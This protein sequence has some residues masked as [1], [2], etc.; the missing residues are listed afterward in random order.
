MERIKHLRIPSG[1][2]SDSGIDG[3]CSS[4]LDSATS[5]TTTASDTHSNKTISASSEKDGNDS[6][7]TI[8]NIK[9]EEFKTN[10]SSSKNNSES[11]FDCQSPESLEDDW[12][13]IESNPTVNKPFNSQIKVRNESNVADERDRFSP[14]EFPAEFQTDEGYDNTEDNNKSFRRPVENTDRS[15]L[16]SKE[17]KQRQNEEIVIMES[18]S[19]SSETG[20]WE[21]VFPQRANTELKESCKSFINNERTAC[22]SNS[23]RN[24]FDEDIINPQTVSSDQ[25]ISDKQ[26]N[27]AEKNLE[28]DFVP[29]AT[30]SLGACFIDAST[31]LDESEIAYSSFP[32]A[33]LTSDRNT[34]DPT[35]IK[36][37]DSHHQAANATNK[38]VTDVWAKDEPIQRLESFHKDFQLCKVNKA[39]A[40][41]INAGKYSGQV[42]QQSATTR[43][44]NLSDEQKLNKRDA[45]HSIEHDIKDQFCNNSGRPVALS[46]LNDL[47]HDTIRSDE[48]GPHFNERQEQERKQG[49]FL[50]QNSIQQFSGH[51]MSP[52]IPYYE[53]NHSDFSLPSAY[54][55]SSDPYNDCASTF[56]TS[57]QYS[58]NYGDAH[59]YTESN[60][61]SRGILSEAETV[62]FPDTPHNSIIHVNLSRNSIAPS[63]SAIASLS[64][65]EGYG[66]PSSRR[67]SHRDDDAMPIVSGGASVKDF[68][69][70]QC[71]S[72]TARRKDDICPIISQ[73]MSAA[74]FVQPKCESPAVRRRS[75]ACPIISLGM[76]PEDFGP[77]KPKCDSPSVR[78]RSDDCPIISLN[79]STADF[80]GN[81][82]KCDSPS[83]R[84]KTEACPIIS[85]GMSPKDFEETKVKPIERP[86]TSIVSSWVVDMSDCNGK[87]KRRC[88]ESS[89]SSIDNMA[90]SAADISLDR[91]SS[92][93][94]HK[95]LG[96]YVSLNDMKP[97]KLGE[98]YLSKS[99]NYKPTV[100]TVREQ[101]KKGTGFFVDFSESEH[102]LT[103]TPPPTK[104]TET[105]PVNNDKKNIFSMFIDFGDDKKS[106]SKKDSSPKLSS[107]LPN[108][109]DI[110]E[111]RSLENGM[112]SGNSDRAKNNVVFNESDSPVLARRTHSPAIATGDIKRHSW[113]TSKD[114]NQKSSFH[115]HK[116]SVSVSAPTTEKGIM[117]I[118]DKIPFISKT[119]S[120]SIDTPNSPYDDITC[121]KSLSS[122]SNNSLTSQSSVG[123]DAPDVMTKSAKRRQKDAKINETFDKSSQG[124]LTDGI[125]SKNSSP[126]YTT[127]TEDVTFQN[128]NDDYTRATFMETIPEAR[129]AGSPKKTVASLPSINGKTH[130]METLQ[131]T[132][133]K[134]KQLL[135]TVTEE[136]Q[137]SSYVK[138]S[139]MDKP[140]QRFELHQSEPMS[141]SAGSKIGKLFD[142]NKVGNRNSWHSMSRSVGNVVQISFINFFFNLL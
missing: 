109:S 11:T 22:V 87:G 91:N 14:V 60:R 105:P 72:P 131:A 121:S 130:T 33:N 90:R 89:T 54:S 93:G 49:N 30:T 12:S 117:N 20:S 58:S 103:A 1:S 80:D 45:D 78:R 137:I 26:T 71:D 17:E 138:L 84:R 3:G 74:D 39:E 129:E 101:K 85:L 122:Y 102:S 95:G 24:A 47:P 108:R 125:L 25:H 92:A 88:S 19:V 53:D 57:S 68:A 41:D 124:S 59:D 135:D 126:T 97:P 82:T 7:S 96:F 112:S 100:V 79:S 110:I 114:E 83:V 75:D 35:N 136:V 13:R 61:Y 9:S 86:K 31:L 70:R 66:A 52:K 55:G 104:N 116:R 128:E 77:A 42:S 23:S 111:L 118:L 134:Q 2:R 36:E 43:I 4:S 15:R 94:S 132:I 8:S 113:N 107:S 63:D 6:L 51:T 38:S 48:K 67:R 142:A 98:E 32:N 62:I 120:M 56:D 65:S 21:S 69:P 106:P 115:E 27:N 10:L 73:G 40:D 127:D 139:D 141:K 37:N 123:G 5:L 76:S 28:T 16:S 29:K 34:S 64:S 46:M 99:L 50:F 119:S 18:S 133:E 81:K 44:P 140:L